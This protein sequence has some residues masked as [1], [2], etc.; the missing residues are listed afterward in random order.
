MALAWSKDWLT[1]ACLACREDPLF[2]EAAAVLNR[3]FTVIIRG[4]PAKGVDTDIWFGFHAPTMEKA[5]S[6]E[7]N[8]WET[9]YSL[10][11]PY[12]E[13]HAVNE[14]LKGL[15]ACLLD[16][17]I[18]LRRGSTSYLSMFVPAIERFFQLSRQK[19]TDYLGEFQ[20]VGAR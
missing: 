1:G 5:F 3:S 11:G 7:E 18:A 12:T 6:G 20:C 17:S 8:V 13:W 2:Q 10:E 14:G 19:T 9:D 4:E 16:G 15:V